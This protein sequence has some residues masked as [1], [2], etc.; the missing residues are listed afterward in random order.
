MERDVIVEFLKDVNN[1]LEERKKINGEL[2]NKNNEK[3]PIQAPDT[4]STTRIE[5]LANELNKP[6]KINWW[7][8]IPLSYFTVLI[9]GI[10]YFVKYFNKKKKRESMKNEYE[11]LLDEY[12]KKLEIYKEKHKEYLIQLSKWK[13]IHDEEV[14]EILNR[15]NNLNNRIKTI[16]NE[17][18]FIPIQYQTEEAFKYICDMMVSSQFSLKES[19]D[20]YNETRKINLENNKLLEMEKANKL[21]E[22]HNFIV[23]GQKRVLEQQNSLISDQNKILTD[24]N[25]IATEQNK[26]LSKQNSI[27]NKQNDILDKTRKNNNLANA[28]GIVQH[29]NTNKLLEEEK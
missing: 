29:H 19:I 24:R 7:I 11:I 22:Q 12:N 28:I 16:I 10:I 13:K 15:L 4:L 23:E 8:V 27:L 25:Q 26:I 2:I 18:N 20:S 5:Y 14:N 1:L 6:L 17:N 9:G 21:S 3:C